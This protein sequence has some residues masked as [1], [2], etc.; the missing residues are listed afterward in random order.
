MNTCLHL[1]VHG[2]VQG[3]SF[4]AHTRRVATTQQLSGWAQNC[5]DGSVDIVLVGP[6]S[7]IDAA[8]PAILSGPAGARV[9][10]VDYLPAPEHPPQDGFAI[11]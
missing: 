11:L 10:R 1:R 6:A 4:R 7:K 9:D 3:V 2:R 8:K 5:D